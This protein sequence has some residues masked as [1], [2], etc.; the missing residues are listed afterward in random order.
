MEAIWK[1]NLTLL[2]SRY[3]Q[4]AAQI[5]NTKCN[6]H[7]WSIEKSSSGHP[8]LVYRETEA[9]PG[10]LIHSRHDPVRE[11]QRQAEAIPEK[12]ENSVIIL[13][14][15][16]LGY[17]AEALAKSNSILIIIER[18]KDL[19][20][21]A[22][23]NRDL[24]GLLAPGK[25]I[26][27]LE[28]NSAISTVLALL[29]KS[30]PGGSIQKPHIIKN[31]ALC[32]LTEE[33]QIWYDEAERRIHTWSSRDE[34]NAATLQRFGT[35][36]TKNLA[37]NMEG[38]LHFP[39]IKYLTNILK[40]TTIPV[41]L[42]AAGPS[43]N[44]IEPFLKEIHSRCIIVAV[45][46][47]LRFLLRFGIEPDFVVS[48]DPQYWNAQHLHRQN[49][50][51]AALIAE[52][53]V[54][55]PLLRKP[56]G[57]APSA[58]KRIF[59]C[60][61]LFPLGR[62]IEDR[63]DVKGPLGAGGSVATTAWDFARHL[64]PAAIWTAGLDLSFPNFQTHFKGALFE[65]NAHA[66]SGRLC[67]AETLSVHAL[68]S[69]QPFMASS[70]NGKKVLSDRR[71]SL[72][73]VWFEEQ[74]K[75]SSQTSLTNYSLSPDGLA[76]PGFISSEAEKLLALPQRREEIDQLL[77][78]AYSNIDHDFNKALSERTESYS[79]AYGDLIR[80]LEA[81]RDNAA[82]AASAAGK[83]FNF[84]TTDSGKTN[85]LLKKLDRANAAIAQSPVKDAA[86][87]LFPPI[88]EL[89]KSLTESDPLK[90]HLEF[91][92][93]FYTSLQ[94]SAD[95]TLKVLKKESTN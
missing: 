1:Q 90:R 17:T 78:N 14:G 69:G 57:E 62:F 10:I 49:A 84:S 39:G 11:G 4:L 85:A 83:G 35:R 66:G 33:D 77:Q 59:F 34:I 2:R 70:A 74:C 47:A 60:Q 20:R 41:F 80:G 86:G 40:N 53:A 95:Y 92:R 43:L 65:E 61:S 7:Q 50:P 27:I 46:T 91:S 19:F 25:V 15:F 94:E 31:R 58:F 88:S 38:V 63:S 82:E 68:Q 9:S 5:E 48:V 13:L 67:P 89:E 23:E 72:Y 30:L 81:I 79:Q 28:D 6:N 26:F 21:F 18:H 45:D 93:L 8:T 32:T 51:N 52:S 12:I 75:I 87:F 76:I 55:P 22:L 37:A 56:E 3:A 71:L 73:A 64:G 16:G 54:Y 42:A 36:W 44:R 29:E 24:Q